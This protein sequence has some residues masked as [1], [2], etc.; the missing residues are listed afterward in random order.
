[1]NEK[2]DEAGLGIFPA[3]PT[4]GALVAIFR[5]DKVEEVN[6]LEK[7]RTLRMW[8]V[9]AYLSDHALLAGTLFAALKER[10]NHSLLVNPK[11]NP[12][13]IYLHSGGRR[14]VYYG[15]F[16]GPDG[17]L[18]YIAVKVHAKLPSNALLLAR[19]PINALL[20]VFV[21]NNPMPLLIH[22]LE[23][24]SPT[25]GDTL[26]SE[27]LMPE[28][29]GVMMGPLG[30]IAQAVPFAPYDAL[31][32]EA[33]VS[34]SPFYRL[35]CGWKMYEGTDKIRGHVRKECEN[36][37]LSAKLPADPVIAAAD[38]F[39]FGFGA[40]FA[41]GVTCARDLF[42]KLR[43]TRDAISHF[44]IDTDEGQ[45]GV[46]V[47]DGAQLRHYSM[48]AA[49]MLHYS[50]QA[51]EELRLFATQSGIHFMGRSAIVPMPQDRDKFVIRAAD[52]GIE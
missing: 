31:Y 41:K 45:A 46:Y 12:L 2:Q 16:N 9:R 32:R 6:Q 14:A 51:L 1:M 38:L 43:E 35:I 30:G 42:E 11:E 40:D 19:G 8:E 36:R 13:W 24:V 39:G 4:P 50:H 7:E 28:A 33:L 34:P 20:D 27:C 48:S 22:R 47:A 52:Y 18:D 37:K 26:I 10:G 21:R 29:R 44:L 25:S 49:A 17:K 15:L 5:S 23:L 3:N